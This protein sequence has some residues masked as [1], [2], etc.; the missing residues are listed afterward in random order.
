MDP[1][2][3]NNNTRHTGSWRACDVSPTR[4]FY[5]QS[6]RGIKIYVYDTAILDWMTDTHPSNE[7]DYNSNDRTLTMTGRV[8]TMFLLRYGQV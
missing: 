7:W 3:I 4:K 5:T 8:Y 1:L 2:H 6:T